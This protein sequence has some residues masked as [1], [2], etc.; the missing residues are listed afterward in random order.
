MLISGAVGIKNAGKRH[1]V[2]GV[3]RCQTYMRARKGFFCNDWFT[4]TIKKFESEF[5]AKKTLFTVFL[6]QKCHCS[7][8]VLCLKSYQRWDF[9]EVC[10]LQKWRHESGQQS[11]LSVCPILWWAVQLAQWLHQTSPS[12]WEPAWQCCHGDHDRFSLVTK[13]A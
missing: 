1:F 12:P 8:H 5:E 7:F 13:Q 10:F 11:P 2:H 4:K 9:L 3:L 6:V